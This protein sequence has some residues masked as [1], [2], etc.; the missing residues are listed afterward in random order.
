MI[1]FIFLLTI[2][3][4]LFGMYCLACGHLDTPPHQRHIVEKHQ[5]NTSKQR[6]LP[7]DKQAYRTKRPEP[8]RRVQAQPV[9]V[10][11][12]KR[13]GGSNA[14]SERLASYSLRDIQQDTTVTTDEDESGLCVIC[15]SKL[16]ISEI[17]YHGDYCDNCVTGLTFDPPAHEDPTRND[18]N[19]RNRSQHF[20]KKKRLVQENTMQTKPQTKRGIRHLTCHNCEGTGQT[21][22]KRTKTCF[23]CSGKGWVDVYQKERTE[24]LCNECDGTGTVC[25]EDRYDCKWCETRGYRIQVVELETI[26]KQNQCVECNGTGKLETTCLTCP[27]CNG[28]S[29][30][31]CRACDESGYIEGECY[32]DVCE[33]TGIQITHEDIVLEVIREA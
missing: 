9:S 26:Q 23:S 13:A 20:V 15:D 12:S 6:S 31:N 10:R 24:Q 22:T 14:Q 17:N 3:V 27:H 19:R 2:G 16:R 18:V 25:I 8:P 5:K 1:Q 7:V 29:G 33:G 28:E 21:A 32:C 4:S 30:A 11:V